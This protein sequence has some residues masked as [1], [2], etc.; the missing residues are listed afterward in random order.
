MVIVYRH[1]RLDR[2]EPFYVGIGSTVKRAYEKNNRNE[3]WSKIV[4]KTDYEVEILFEDLSWEE[5][6]NKEREFISLYGR[7]DLKTGTLVN[8]TD[9]GDGKIN[10]ITPDATKSKM[11]KVR[12]GYKLPVKVKN[13]IS[14]SLTGVCFSEDR[15]ENISKGRKGKGIGPCSDLRRASISAAKLNKQQTK[16]T[17]IHC[18]KIGGVSAMKRYHFD[19]CKHRK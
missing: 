3:M 17:C 13:K 18:N 4:N 12:T 1:I 10:F 2:N 14:N 11:S 16:V 5:A 19:N 15:K 9:G 8:M 6:C 7:K